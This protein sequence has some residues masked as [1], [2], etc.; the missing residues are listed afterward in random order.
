MKTNG[1]TPALLTGQ[2]FAGFMK[3]ENQRV[4]DILGRLGLV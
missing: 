4:K 2:D 1:W 3:S